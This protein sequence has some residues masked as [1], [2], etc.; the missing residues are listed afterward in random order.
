M[1]DI[2]FRGLASDCRFVYGHL[3]T[4]ELPSGQ[5][6]AAIVKQIDNEWRNVVVDEKTVGQLTGK[7]DENGVDIYVGDLFQDDEPG[8]YLEVRWDNDSSTYALY[9]VESGH[10][11]CD[12]ADMYMD[13]VVVV[14]NIH[15]NS[16]LLGIKR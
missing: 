16:N 9:D 8:Y 7:K 11:C 3:F 4:E 2:L 14:G 12:F 13:K 1:R 5:T 10:K 6:Y 15:Q